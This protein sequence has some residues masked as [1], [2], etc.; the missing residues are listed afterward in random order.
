[1]RIN[2][3]EQVERAVAAVLVIDP[4]D[5]PGRSWD[6]LAHLTD[7]LNGALVEADDRTHRI[8]QLGVEIEHVL[9]PGHIGAIHLRNAPHVLAPGLDIVLL[10]SPAHRFA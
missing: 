8:G 5:R 1:M 4:L 3:H 6:G 2:G 9:H 7:Q 10:Q